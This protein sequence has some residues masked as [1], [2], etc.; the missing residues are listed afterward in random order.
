MSYI[1]SYAFIGITDVRLLDENSVNQLKL[2]DDLRTNSSLTRNIISANKSVNKCL[3]LN[4]CNIHRL[5]VSVSI[6]TLGSF[7][8][9]IN[10]WLF[11]FTKCYLINFRQLLTL[12]GKMTSVGRHEFFV[13]NGK[14]RSFTH[15]LNLR[16]IFLILCKI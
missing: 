8:F 12:C 3:T 10:K 9:S 7:C 15:R 14:I 2:T 5:K 1:L 4:A 13:A 11:I 6:Y 16:N